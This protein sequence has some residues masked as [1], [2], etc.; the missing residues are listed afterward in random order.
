VSTGCRG[1][2]ACSPISSSVD[3]EKFLA[4]V[5]T[6][7]EK[8]D[9]SLLRKSET[10]AV[11]LTACWFNGLYKTW[12]SKKMNILLHESSLFKGFQ[13]EYTFVFQISPLNHF[14]LLLI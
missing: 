3:K 14:F 13:R 1:R 12:Y 8:P 7:P 10:T 9:M 4:P 2:E 11:F 6:E 5:T